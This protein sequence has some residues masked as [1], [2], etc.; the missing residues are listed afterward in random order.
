MENWICLRKAVNPHTN[1]AESEDERK[2][3]LE[4]PLV[5][6]YAFEADY[7][8]LKPL[9]ARYGLKTG[10]V[11]SF[12]K[13][14]EKYTNIWSSDFNDQADICEMI[15]AL[16][17]GGVIEGAKLGDL[18]DSAFDGID[19]PGEGVES[20]SE[21]CAVSGGSAGQKYAWYIHLDKWKA[22]MGNESNIKGKGKI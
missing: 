3:R 17:A 2:R 11:D 10:L 21:I 6:D 4:A 7:N 18:N 19:C 1:R 14:V 22:K 12:G 5:T 16:I 15:R 20:Q 9:K 8:W 13:P